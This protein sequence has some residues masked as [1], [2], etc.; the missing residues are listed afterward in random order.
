MF[1]ALDQTS[2]AAQALHLRLLWV[3]GDSVEDGAIH[4]QSKLPIT[5][6]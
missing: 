5:A 3:A 1:Q 2:A 6:E 4:L